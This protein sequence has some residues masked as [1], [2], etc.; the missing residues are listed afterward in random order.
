MSDT[1]IVAVFGQ[2]AVELEA[3]TQLFPTEAEA[4]AALAQYENGAH[5]AEVAANYCAYSGFK[6]KQA[7]GKSNVITDF[8]AWVDA[9]APAAETAVVETTEEEQF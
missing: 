3:G 7:V 6:D 2:F 4:A 5:H 1:K 8:L 9:G